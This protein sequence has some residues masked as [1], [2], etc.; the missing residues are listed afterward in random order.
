[1]MAKLRGWAKSALTSRI[2]RQGGVA[3]VITVLFVVLVVLLNVLLGSLAAQNNW[4]FDLTAEGAF[5]LTQ[6]SLDFL[7]GLGTQINIYVLMSEPTLTAAGD[8]F[9]QAN[10]VLRQYAALS[11]Y[12][13]LSYIDLTQN[14]GFASRFPQFQ[15]NAQTIL[16]T[17]DGRAETISIFD[18]FNIET[19]AFG[20]FIASS[21]AEQVLTGMLVL[22]TM[23]YQVTISMAGGFGEA[24]SAALVNLL[25]AHHY[26]VVTQNLLTE[27]IDP[28][29]SLLIINS[30]TV[31]YP[32]HV[33]AELEA[34]L[35]NERETTILY[36]ASA[37]QPPLPNL[38]AFLAD[39]GII[40]E[41]GLV[42]QSD[43]NLTLGGPFISAVQY[44][45]E[46]Y[47]RHALEFFSIMPNAR[48]L[49]FAFG[50]SGSRRTDSLM[51]FSSSAA[52]RPPEADMGWTAAQAEVFGPFPAVAI[53]YDEVELGFMEYR[54]SA[55]AVFSSRDFID[56]NMLINPYIGN[57]Q[58]MLGFIQARTD[59]M[60]DIAIAPTVI[61]LT[62][63]PVN[64]F[65]VMLFGVVFVIGLPLA[66]V[67]AG[68]VVFF[69]R[70]HM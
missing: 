14:P 62:P 29:A 38:E 25:E 61:G 30:P 46:L 63:L 68:G 21:Q 11:D 1:M 16:L 27:S 37:E 48:P 40:V 17:T 52:I 39:W 28:Q 19:D 7:E 44:T 49:D 31:D 65:Q 56:P 26:L 51:I 5:V 6:E 9:I 70:R 53:T 18:L 2:F 23:E 13:T 59:H 67:V 33:I 57:A 24:N 34:F 15:L 12:I 36:F 47:S 20:T 22:L 50:A 3:S 42:Y 4:R 60:A 10:E 69:R 43:S 54:V 64:D 55:L 35:Q 8:Y 58:Y 45:E 41:P 66:V 32:E